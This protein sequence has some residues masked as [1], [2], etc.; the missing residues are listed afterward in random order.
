VV[1]DME[2]APLSDA[3]VLITSTS[4][5]PSAGS[6]TEQL[7]TDS[8]GRYSSSFLPAGVYGVSAIQD[9]F[10]P[11]AASVT[12][13]DG[14]PTTTQNFMLVRT[15]PFTIAGL[16]THATGAPIVATVRLT[17]NSAVPGIITTKTDPA[18]HYSITMDPGSYNGDYTVE[19]TA[20]GFASDSVTI[21]IPN[22]AKIALNF[23]LAKQGTLTG[24]VTDERGLPLGGAK[25]T[26]GSSKTFSDAAG[27]YSIM[28]D[29]G[30]YAMTASAP[31]FTSINLSISIPS[32]LTVTQDFVLSETI[33]GSIT[34]TVFDESDGAPRGGAR[35]AA[36][37]TTLTT[38]DANGKYTL[39]NLQPGPTQVV[40]SLGVRYIP[41]KETVTVISGETVPQDFVL[42]RKGTTT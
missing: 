33:T 23:T 30:L 29:P 9:G 34:G 36:M 28:V 3:L 7:S 12:V 1:T 37:N 20:L 17:E 2:G 41:D 4:F 5:I 26:V 22:G 6:N 21:T 14:V 19:A 42:V 16:V 25:V 40:A 38:T 8:Q 39:T 32:G 13:L 10:V 31:G 15:V 27:T 35:V 11:A 24:H 18:G